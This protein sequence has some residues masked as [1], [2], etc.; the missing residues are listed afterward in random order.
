MELQKKIRVAVVGQ[1]YVG[2]PLTLALSSEGCDVIGLDI[3][4]VVLNRLRQGTSKI[5]DVDDADIQAAIERG[6]V[7]SDDYLLLSGI[8][9]VVI[10]V[11]TPLRTDR[12][13]DLRPLIEAVNSVSAHLDSGTLV[14]S[15]S[16]SFP[17]TTE[18]IVLPA[19][20]R[21]L[22]RVGEDFY[23]AFSPERVDP[24]N[25]EF[26]IAN[27]PRIVGGITTECA[28]RATSFYQVV[29]QEV[30]VVSGPREAEMAKLLE[31]TY[32][33]VNIALVNEMAKVCHELEIDV[34]E[35]IEAAAT[36]PFGFQKFTPGPGVGGHCI[37][38]DP[39]YLS[40]RVRE[41]LGRPFEFIEL[42]T[43]V[44]RQMP[45][46]VVGRA[47]EILV[48]NQKKI[49]EASILLLGVTY[50]PNVG[51]LRESPALEVAEGFAN[52]GVLV[53]YHDPYIPTWSFGEFDLT[54]E[55]N[56]GTA[57]EE[58]TLT[59]LLQDHSEY[60]EKLLQ[61]APLLLDTRGIIDQREKR[62]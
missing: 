48:A 46:Y 6:T 23:L 26:T 56:L 39:V 10:C 40:A 16:T 3:D 30:Y 42:A 32:R 14:I 27:T 62:L 31:N 45:H 28:R 55:P 35:V 4:P 57:I 60:E 24:G 44:N 18:E 12:S 29:V 58:T 36:K 50:K 11:P 52:H 53:R 20:E 1:G 54:S 8:S 5:D 15:E 47:L 61:S 19:L 21:A 25:A 41:K 37:P 33:H 38:I 22:G 9:V 51:D 13:P 43:R 59:V 2:L 34:W 49:A 17:G 7:F